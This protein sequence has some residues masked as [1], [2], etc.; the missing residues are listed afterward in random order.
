MS[1]GIKD[2]GVGGCGG[3]SKS[4]VDG[5]GWMDESDRKGTSLNQVSICTCVE[6]NHLNRM[7]LFNQGIV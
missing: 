1:R 7:Q 6:K 3:A 4:G 5:G 2:D